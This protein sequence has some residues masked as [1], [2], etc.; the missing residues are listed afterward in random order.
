[1]ARRRH[2]ALL[3]PHVAHPR[4]W[5]LRTRLGAGAAAAVVVAIV[6]AAAVLLSRRRP[7]GALP[8][9]VSLAAPGPGGTGPGGRWALQHGL[10][11]APVCQQT[12]TPLAAALPQ[13][14]TT[15]IRTHDQ[16]ALDI[17]TIFPDPSADPEDPAAYDFA[18]GDAL[19]S[20]I[21]AVGHRAYLRVGVSWPPGAP[22][23]LPPVP[24]WSLC[25]PARL[26]ARIAL[27]TVQH[28]NDAAWGA[29]GFSGK[30]LAAIEIW[31]E[32]DGESPVM[33]CGSPAQFYALYN[34]TAATLKA[35]DQSLRVGGPAVARPGSAAYGLGF[36]E[37]VIASR[38]P[39]DF[40]SWHSYGSRAGGNAA[41]VA[42][43]VAAVRAALDN[44]G[45]SAVEQHITEWNTDPLPAGTQH[46]SPLAAAYVAAALGSFASGGAHVALFYPGCEGVGASSWGL[47]QDGGGGAAAA[48]RPETYAYRAV[49][50]TLR[51]T[52][53]P[54]AV[55]SAPKDA[56]AIAGAGAPP[57]AGGLAANMSFV[58]A[59]QSTAYNVLSLSVAGLAP[60]AALTL[61]TEVVDAAYAG[62]PTVSRA[63]VAAAADGTLSIAVKVAPPDV[64]RV[65]LLLA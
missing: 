54:A 27:H 46:D 52:P 39:L 6:V 23:V 55:T 37:F 43:T 12:G 53:W 41:S 51:D 32:P 48:W 58:V 49:G 57:V 3:S 42:A 9:A 33:F 31:N 40:F 17:F 21:I 22:P 38:A 14:G 29:G 30:T 15:L 7:A 63:S 65:Q 60:R 10:N 18:A 2:E 11:Q 20:S 34:E 35:Y 19:F 24:A 45:L 28:Y 44:A 1:M 59:T 16:R 26:L 50:Q 25:P 56:V 64:V 8:V 47:F 36:V 4:D 62:E 13:L 61:L 5:S